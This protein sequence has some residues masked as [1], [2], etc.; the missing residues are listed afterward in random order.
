MSND[1]I[2]YGQTDKRGRRTRQTYV[3]AYV[4]DRE[5]GIAKPLRGLWVPAPLSPLSVSYNQWGT[6]NMTLAGLPHVSTSPMMSKKFSFRW[7]HINTLAMLN[8]EDVVRQAQGENKYFFWYDIT[9]VNIAS[10]YLGR[11]VS[12]LESLSPLV[13]TDA[14]AVTAT[15]VEDR[16][17]NISFTKSSFRDKYYEHYVVPPR[18]AIFLSS[19]KRG[20]EQCVLYRSPNA[21]SG[22]FSASNWG[23]STFYYQNYFN[24]PQVFSVALQSSA[25][26]ELYPLQVIIGDLTDSVAMPPFV[27]APQGTSRLRIVPGSFS[28]DTITMANGGQHSVSF[29]AVEVSAW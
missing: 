17:N 7:P 20:V 1:T 3:S 6:D 8:L 13:L 24:D 27:A 15:P 2:H 12:H 16:P 4:E 21:R 5:T 22:W 23:A 10:T 19:T 28:V 11:P 29:E 26:Q 18:K 14:G 25:G 9:A